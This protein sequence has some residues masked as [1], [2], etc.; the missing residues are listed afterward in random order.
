MTATAI[1]TGSRFNLRR[2]AL[3]AG[4]FRVDIIRQLSIYAAITIGLFI[5][6]SIPYTT[7]LHGMETFGLAVM[8]F[9]APVVF[10]RE[11]CR[12]VDTM[13]PV[14]AKEKYTFILIYT[15]L[16]VPL[17]IIGL[18]QLMHLCTLWT[19]C[20]YSITQMQDNKEM[21][22]VFGENRATLFRIISTILDLTPTCTVLMIVL[23]ARSGIITKSLLGIVATLLLFFIVGGIAG[24]ISVVPTI[25]EVKNGAMEHFN[26]TDFLSSVFNIT[27]STLSAVCIIYISFALWRCYRLISHSQH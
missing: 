11:R 15:F 16:I 20:T 17:L 6:A 1:S 27:Y 21:L 24:V 25:N 9:M 7:G 12:I 19:G 13:L 14:T 26:Q 2:L 23:K 4:Y 3:Y 5:L 10:G 18:W 8:I 22:K